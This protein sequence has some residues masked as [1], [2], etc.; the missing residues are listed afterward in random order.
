MFCVQQCHLIW[1][2]IIKKAWI[3]HCAI[4]TLAHRAPRSCCC[5]GPVVLPSYGPA[6]A[7]FASSGRGSLATHT[8]RAAW[9]ETS[10]WHGTYAALLAHRRFTMVVTSVGQRRGN[11]VDDARCK[12]SPVQKV[13]RSLLGRCDTD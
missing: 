10:S 5:Y 4:S 8:C 12:M 13:P 6:F 7:L 9:L 2:C 1:G 11:N 3:L